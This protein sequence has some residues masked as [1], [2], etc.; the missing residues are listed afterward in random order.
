M[1]LTSNGIFYADTSTEMSIA[2]IT[3]AMAQSIATAQYPSSG[4]YKSDMG[5]VAFTKTGT[6]AAQV[7][8]GTIITLG[9][10]T[11]NF[12]SATTITMPTLTA[13]TDYFIYAHIG[14]TAQAVAATGTWPTP[15][16][17]PPSGGYL[18][19]GFHYAAGGNASGVA[20]GDTTPQINE[21][22]FWDLKFKP[23][24][25]DP[26]GMALVANM[27]WSDIYLLNRNP[28]VYGTSRNAQPIADGETGG[29]TTAIVPNAYGGNGST[30][31]PIQSWFNTS[32]CLMAFGKRLPKFREFATLAY[33]STSNVSRGNDPVTTGLATTNAGSS[34]ADQKFTS[35]WGV[36]QA[37]GV[38]WQW[39]D[40]FGGGTAASAWADTNGGRGQLYQQEN[41]VLLSGNWSV[42]VYSGSRTAYWADAPSV[43]LYSI[44]GRGVCDHLILA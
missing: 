38:M 26:R 35:K 22:S 41:A 13:G 3:A 2:D 34:N 20:G 28:Q 23:T 32:E 24:A 29:T 6:G 18:I 17:A 11:I 14:G 10:L 9:V 19:G 21:Y 1:P 16:G 31:Y 15:V 12:A 42:G 4:M 27:F 25:F 39:G 44:G 30:R 36:M 40:E 8:A 37:S 33:G 5:A 43:S 7:K